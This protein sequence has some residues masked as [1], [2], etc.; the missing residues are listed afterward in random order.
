MECL[1]PFDISTIHPTPKAQGQ[2]LQKTGQK[3]Y[4]VKGT[5]HW[6]LG[7]VLDMTASDP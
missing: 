7:G 2:I 1:P 6:R 4:R 3:N 5:E